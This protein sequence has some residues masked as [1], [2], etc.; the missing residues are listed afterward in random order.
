MNFQ[1]LSADPPS[2]F[3]SFFGV[4]ISTEFSITNTLFFYS[5]GKKPMY[6]W[7]VLSNKCKPSVLESI[8][9]QDFIKLHFEKLT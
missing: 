4:T 6:N 2:S 5:S 3:T 8:L 7:L 9:Q 1:L